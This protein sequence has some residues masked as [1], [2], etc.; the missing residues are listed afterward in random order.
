MIEVFDGFTKKI[1]A[2]V[3]KINNN[4]LYKFFLDNKNTPISIMAN[5][6]NNIYFILQFS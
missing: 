4:P 5:V 6:K 3:Y 2:F 1:N